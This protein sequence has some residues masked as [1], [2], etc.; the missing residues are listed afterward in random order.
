M[1]FYNYLLGRL[2]NEFTADIVYYI[3]ITIALLIVCAILNFI[4]NRVVLKLITK[5]IMNNKNKWD[6]V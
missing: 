5:L 1:T 2:P 4:I 6:D 3:L